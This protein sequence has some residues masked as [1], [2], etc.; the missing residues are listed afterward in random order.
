MKKIIDKNTIFSF[1]ISG[2]I[3]GSIGIYATSL[4]NGKDIS[5]TPTDASWEVNNVNDAI[6][7]LYI[8]KTELD[9][10]NSLGDAT[11]ADILSGKTAVVKGNVITGTAKDSSSIKLLGSGYS[12]NQTIDFSTKLSNYSELTGANFIIEIVGLTGGSVSGRLDKEYNTHYANVTA[13]NI[14]KS[15]NNSTGQLTV[16][17]ANIYVTAGTDKNTKIVGTGY[18]YQKYNV[19]YVENVE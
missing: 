5:Y 6:N 2:I 3:F 10:L 9:N 1:I 17:G 14:S 11:A 8:M 18:V 7:S 12:G 13:T 4:Y 19:Y 15:Y 16:S